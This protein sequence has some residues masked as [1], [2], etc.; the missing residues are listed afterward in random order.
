MYGDLALH[1]MVELTDWLTKLELHPRD[2]GQVP[3]N[4]SCKIMLEHL[5]ILKFCPIISVTGTNGKGT[6][7]HLIADVLRR[8]GYKV[9]LF[10][11]PHLL[12]YNERICVNEVEASDWEILFAFEKI[13]EAEAKRAPAQTVLASLRN[14]RSPSSPQ[15][16]QFLGYFDHAFLAAMILFHKA[17]VDML[18]LEV[19]IGG[20]LDAVNSMDADVAVITT[21][22]FDHTELLGKT[23]EAIGFEKAGL[24]RPRQ[25]AV[26]GDVDTP[27]TVIEQ[28]QNQGAELLLRGRDFQLEDLPQCSFVNEQ[29]PIQNALTAWIALQALESKGLARVDRLQFQKSLETLKLPGRIQ[30]LCQQPEILVDV[31]HNPESARYLAGYLKAHPVVGKTYAV[32]SGLCEKDLAQVI[33]PLKELIH[34]W[35][36]LVLDHPRAAS[37]AQLCDALQGCAIAVFETMIDLDVSLERQ[38]GVDDRV[39]VFGSF[40]L[41]SLFLT[42]HNS[43]NT[44]F[45]KGECHDE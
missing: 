2:A 34:G 22:D 6:T 12:R 42:C 7:S 36:I 4:E 21:I 13:A 44:V 35:N 28:A 32:F 27:K 29:L 14:S 33:G 30:V 1:S 10:T 39:V 23:R 45:H 37:E 26:C 11:S 19:G 25:I 15:P 24:F 5:G 9:G 18:V 43:K 20:R 38:V 16:Q 17:K 31:A 8:S 41:V 40:V 3:A